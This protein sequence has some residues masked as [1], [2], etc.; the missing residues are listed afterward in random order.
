[1]VRRVQGKAGNGRFLG[2]GRV[3]ATVK[4]FV[5]D[6]GT[7]G[8]KDKGDNPSS[9]IDIRESLDGYTAAIAGAQS[10][11]ASYNSVRGVKCTATVAV[12]DALKG[13]MQF[14]AGGRRLNGHG[15]CRG[16]PHQLRRVDQAGARHVHGHRN[17]LERALRQHAG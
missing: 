1:M 7:V 9:D 11:M 12:T 8:G 14:E 2:P 13:D 6:G 10:V 5:G 15:R 3:I 4:H 16:A 17:S